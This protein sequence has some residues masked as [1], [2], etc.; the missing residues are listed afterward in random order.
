MLWLSL[1]KIFLVVKPDQTFQPLV[2]QRALYANPR[3]DQARSSRS[4][5]AKGGRGGRGG[6]THGA[7]HPDKKT[8]AKPSAGSQGDGVRD[9]STYLCN[10]CKQPGHFARDC[11][12][13]KAKS[14][15]AKPTRRGTAGICLHFTTEVAPSDSDSDDSNILG[16][17]SGIP[18]SMLELGEDNVDNAVEVAVAANV[19]ADVVVSVDDA[20][21]ATVVA[22]AVVVADKNI[23]RC[24]A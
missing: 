24:Q 9:K 2:N 21:A 6:R 10:S 23:S 12:N 1:I 16:S 17:D 22:D 7:P 15:P 14:T 13:S 11:P 3:E 20:V 19:V 5:P 18:D 4:G 8:S